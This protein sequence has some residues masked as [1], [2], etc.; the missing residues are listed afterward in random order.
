MKYVN[1]RTGSDVTPYE[2]IDQ[3]ASGK[4]LTIREMDNIAKEGS[5]PMSNE[6][7]YVS[8]PEHGRI[9]KVSKRKNG[10]YYKVGQPMTWWA[11]GQLSDEPYAHYDYSF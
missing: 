1:L 8:N 3:S 6:W 5:A 7:D 4:T 10:R 11:G 9:V 2:V